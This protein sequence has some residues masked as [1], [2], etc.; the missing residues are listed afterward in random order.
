MAYSQ[1]LFY[2]E[3]RIRQ[4]ICGR[5][6]WDHQAWPPSTPSMYYHRRPLLLPM[7]M[8]ILPRKLPF[9]H[10]PWWT[11]P[12][13]SALPTNLSVARTFPPLSKLSNGGTSKGAQIS[14]PRGSQSISTQVQQLWKDIWNAHGRVLEAQDVACKMMSLWYLRCFPAL[15]ITQYQLTKKLTLIWRTTCPSSN[16]QQMPTSLSLTT[17]QRS[18]YSSLPLST[19]RP[20]WLDFEHEIN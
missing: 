15:I 5:F 9:S 3:K 12:I 20:R 7:P 14:R 6:H 4:L 16:L 1:T 18:M 17:T 13:A 10:T 11:R 8:P 19:Q 2:E